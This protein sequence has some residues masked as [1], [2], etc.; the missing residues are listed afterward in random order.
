MISYSGCPKNEA[1]N[2]FQ[3]SPNIYFQVLHLLQKWSP[4][5]QNFDYWKFLLK[6]IILVDGPVWQLSV[7]SSGGSDKY[8]FPSLGVDPN[9]VTVYSGPVAG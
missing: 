8:L 7:D 4:R 1:M 5:A 9:I 3:Y 2:S 6:W